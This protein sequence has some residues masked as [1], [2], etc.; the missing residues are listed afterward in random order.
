MLQEPNL[1]STQLFNFPLQEKKREEAR[2]ER[3]VESLKLGMELN[4]KLVKSPTNLHSVA[5]W[6]DGFNVK[7]CLCSEQEPSSARR[8]LSK[9]CFLFRHLWRPL[10]TQPWSC[11][12]MSASIYSYSD[13]SGRKAL[14]WLSGLSVALHLK[15]STLSSLLSFPLSSLSSF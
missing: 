13:A 6:W 10:L 8:F 3:L 7:R 4:F 2:S 15:V 5:C 14:V 11:C 1:I 12:W 9:L